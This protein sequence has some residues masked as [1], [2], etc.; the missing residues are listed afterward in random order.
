MHYIGGTRSAEAVKPFERNPHRIS[1]CF[2][3]SN[4]ARI[5]L[6]ISSVSPDFLV[7]RSNC[8]CDSD[9]ESHGNNT[10]MVVNDFHST[11][12]GTGGTI[13][14]EVV[15]INAA[16]AGPATITSMDN[17]IW[18]EWGGTGIPNAG[19]FMFEFTTDFDFPVEFNSGEWTIAAQP[20]V[21]VDPVRDDITTTAVLESGTLTLFVIGASLLGFKRRDKKDLIPSP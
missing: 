11:F 19:T 7:Y 2:A 12:T 16:G 17:M 3:F 15:T 6:N 4:P 20:N 1:E 5:T 10:G 18:I 8:I 21:P 14:N 13:D 9:M